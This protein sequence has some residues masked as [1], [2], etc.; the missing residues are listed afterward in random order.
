[1]L[2]I[3]FLALRAIGAMRW[4]SL[5]RAHTSQIDAANL[6][7]Q[8]QVPFPGH[9][10]LSELD[11]LPSPVQRYFCAVLKDAQPIIAATTI[12]M[13]GTMNLSATGDQWKPFTS[14]QRVT[15]HRPGFLW[16]AS[17]DLF[18]GFSV[19]VEDSYIKGQGRLLARLL[20]LFTV[21][22]VHGGGE[23]ARGELM[24][25]FAEAAWYPTALLPSQGVRWTAVDAS[26]ALATLTDG[27]V[28]LT[29][30]FRFDAAGLISSVHAES[31]GAGA[32]A[33]M[34]MLPWDCALSNYQW[35]NGMQ[36][37]CTGEA[38]WI[39]PEGRRAYF[40]GH[41]IQVSHE[42]TH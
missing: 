19:R 31:R 40:V 10:K 6:V 11:G 23:I 8:G 24:R 34:V 30:L 16:D 26:S 39:R 37:P 42:F 41:L 25:F 17:V 14:R 15:T 22:E 4:A 20:G 27:P 35:H 12:E 33:D 7:H 3:A 36:L 21:A 29:L 9:F 13:A 32:G 38:A 28:S 2:L 1:M 5:M 18:P